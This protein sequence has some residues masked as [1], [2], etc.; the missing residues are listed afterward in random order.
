MM[1]L[2]MKVELAVGRLEIL[3]GQVEGMAGRMVG[4][5]VNWW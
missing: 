1:E 4:W 5:R 3:F 2:A